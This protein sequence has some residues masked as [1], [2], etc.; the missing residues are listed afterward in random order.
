MIRVLH[1]VDGR[2]R[3]ACPTTAA[4]LAAGFT[5]AAGVE[6]YAMVATAA[7]VDRMLAGLGVSGPRVEPIS[8][9]A[10]GGAWG[11]GTLRRRLAQLHRASGW[12]GA[13]DVVHAWSV[14]SM[15]LGTLALR[16][17]A[18]VLTLTSPPTRREVAWL[19]AMR[20]APGRWAALPISSTLQRELASGG[21]PPEE[22]PVL[23]PA[24]DLGLVRHAERSALRKGWG[25]EPALDRRTRVLALCSDPP[26]QADALEP[27]MAVILANQLTEGRGVHL[28]LLVHPDQRQ[29]AQAQS[30]LRQADRERYLICDP[31]LES[32]WSV[33]P[34]C[35]GAIAL[36]EPASLRN[37]TGEPTGAGGLSLLWAMASNLTLLGEAAYAVSEVVEN[38]HSGLL[39]QPGQT[40]AL[41]QRLLEIALDDQLAWKLRDSARHEAYSFFSPQRY[42][43]QLTE[44]YRQLVAGEPLTVAPLE[45]T[46]GIR[47]E[48]VRM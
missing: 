30:L 3:Q 23:R 4:L 5:R 13:F 29:R 36:D 31:R 28:R 45:A 11:Y 44:V 17:T 2:G 24:I 25:I 21:I 39:F 38:R 14:G 26:G 47:F 19:Q 9:P 35:D 8:L 41:V 37:L 6:S 34:G 22:A 16:G 40:R 12:P 48:G 46:A 27:L 15:A 43:R 10:W 1:L 32:P 42:A 7:G 18:R 33:L 20:S